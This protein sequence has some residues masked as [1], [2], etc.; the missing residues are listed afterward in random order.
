[1][2]LKI[3]DVADML[4]VQVSTVE[5]WLKNGIIP[6][7]KMN[8]EYRFSRIEIEDWLLQKKKPLDQ[9]KDVKERAVID[10]KRPEGGVKCLVFTGL[11]IKGSF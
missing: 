6:A 9:A 5:K 7:Y 2:D 3:S 8:S 11:C 10:R 4:N 1:M